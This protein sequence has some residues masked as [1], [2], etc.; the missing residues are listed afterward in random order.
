M[1]TRWR[2]PTVDRCTLRANTV[3]RTRTKIVNPPVRAVRPHNVPGFERKDTHLELLRESQGR[4]PASSRHDR[5]TCGHGTPSELSSSSQRLL[6]ASARLQAG[7]VP[8]RSSARSRRLRHR[9]RPRLVNRPPLAAARWHGTMI[10]TRLSP[11][12]RATEPAALGRP[13]AAA[14]CSYVRVCPGGMRSNSCHTCS[15]KLRPGIHTGSSN[16]VR[17]WAK[18]SAN[19]CAAASRIAQSPRPLW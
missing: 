1:D 10:A 12:A 8:A 7:D 11:T 17:A 14:I 3:T 13:I 19:C 15:S 18:Y 5:L 2:H 9:P 4:Q 6:G 16:S